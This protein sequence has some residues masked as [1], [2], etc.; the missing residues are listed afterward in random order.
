MNRVVTSV[1][2]QHHRAVDNLVAA[3]LVN[4]GNGEVVVAL[5]VLARVSIAVPS[6]AYLIQFVC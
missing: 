2:V 6:V 1:E 3:V 5:S 4:V